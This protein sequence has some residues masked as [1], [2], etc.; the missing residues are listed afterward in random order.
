MA[1]SPSTEARRRRR[2]PVPTTIDDQGMTSLGPHFVEPGPLDVI[3]GRGKHILRHPGNHRMRSI[4]QSKL[5]E[6]ANASTKLK[7]SAIV[8]S[9]VDGVRTASPGGG[10]VKCEAGQWYEVG[11]HLAREKIGQT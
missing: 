2:R 1:N 6:Y 10:F 11:D 7:K 4:I 9:I 3:C 8:S 5:E